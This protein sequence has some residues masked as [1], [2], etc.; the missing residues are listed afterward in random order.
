VS[1]F[2]AKK[3][4]IENAGFAV[5]GGFKRVMISPSLHRIMRKESV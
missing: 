3:V 5:S 2:K 4:S 1:Y